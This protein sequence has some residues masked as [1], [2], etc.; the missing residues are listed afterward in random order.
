MITAAKHT[1]NDTNGD[2]KYTP[3]LRKQKKKTK[4]AASEFVYLDNI[5]PRMRFNNSKDPIYYV[6]ECLEKSSVSKLAIDFV[7]DTFFEI[8]N[9]VSRVVR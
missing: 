9:F 6:F 2:G 3:L 1:S 4:C 7:T 5:D 8:T